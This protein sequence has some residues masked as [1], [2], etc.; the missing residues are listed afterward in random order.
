VRIA[1]RDGRAADA[2]ALADLFLA[3]RRTA[4]PWL[5]VVHGDAETRRWIARV[6]LPGGGVRVGEVDG[7]A[8][9]FAV[10]RGGWLEHLYVAPARQ[11][12]G[13]GSLLLDD[14]RRIA[15]AALSLYVFQRNQRA[16]AFYGKRG[17]VEATFS[18]GAAN[19][20]REPDLV[21]RWTATP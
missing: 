15:G 19:E 13:I 9:G 14:A 3:A 21:M 12:A 11:G 5:A 6:L 4:L 1:L 17:F 2:G 18:D 20:E 7:T 10:V 8:A 16:R